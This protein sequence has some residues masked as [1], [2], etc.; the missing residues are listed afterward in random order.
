MNDNKNIH[1]RLQI[2][3]TETPKAID[4]SVSY[5]TG[6]VLKKMKAEQ[7]KKEKRGNVVSKLNLNN[8]LAP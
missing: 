5:K 4:S 2:T 8:E 1:F 7:K 3:R 6:I